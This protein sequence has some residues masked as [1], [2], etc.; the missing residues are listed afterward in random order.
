M[1]PQSSCHMPVESCGSG[2]QIVFKINQSINTHEYVGLHQMSLC[3]S[4][5]GHFALGMNESMY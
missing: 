2:G 4:M 5:P 1:H 3:T